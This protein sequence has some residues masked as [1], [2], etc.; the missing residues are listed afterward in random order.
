MTTGVL[1]GGRAM[2]ESLMVDSC[3]ITALTEP[4][5][6]EEADDYADPAAGATLYTGPC[7]V[8]V[9]DSL[10]VQTETVGEQL[11]ATQRVVV[12]IPV[13]SDPTP[14]GSVVTIT[15]VADISDPSLVDQ[16]YRVTGTHAKTHA[17]AR[18]LPCE[19][20]TP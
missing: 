2:A 10:T 7:R 20:V 17:T 6:D 19:Q 12:S 13:D 1:A 14:I 5:W 16:T 18:R 4:E 15:A 3:T 8:Q 11:V 9:T